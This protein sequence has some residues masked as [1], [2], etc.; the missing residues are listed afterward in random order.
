MVCGSIG[1]VHSRVS[2]KRSGRYARSK[3]D[4]NRNGTPA[5]L[6]ASA[7]GNEVSPPRL[8]SR[9]ATSISGA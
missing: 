3:P 9:I 1:F 6:R 8:M 5:R 2:W 7:T 4:A